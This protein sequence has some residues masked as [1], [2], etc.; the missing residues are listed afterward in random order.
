MS[1]K[2]KITIVSLLAFVGL[3]SVI[4]TTYFSITDSEFIAYGQ[5]DTRE[6]VENDVKKTSQVSDDDDDFSQQFEA[7]LKTYQTP[8]S[9]SITKN[10]E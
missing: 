4:C 6:S 8:F 9:K 1:K 10:Q 2:L 3:V 7:F 5:L